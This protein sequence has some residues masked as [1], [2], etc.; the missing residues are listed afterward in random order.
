MHHRP[1][2]ERS[3]TRTF[4]HNAGQKNWMRCAK[5]VPQIVYPFLIRLRWPCVVSAV[6]PPPAHFWAGGPMPAGELDLFLASLTKRE[7]EQSAD[8][9]STVG[10]SVAEPSSMHA[11]TSA[12]RE[13]AGTTPERKP[14]AHAQASGARKGKPPKRGRQLS[15]LAGRRRAM[16]EAVASQKA[17]MQ[18]LHPSSAALCTATG[19]CAW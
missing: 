12:A 7:Q 1:C 19:Q 18:V 13:T 11:S 6:H 16:D 5:M 10:T 14:R 3:G 15:F 8:E 17:E 2:V 4:L 9:D